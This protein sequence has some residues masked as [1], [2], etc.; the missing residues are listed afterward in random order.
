MKNKVIDMFMRKPAFI[1]AHFVNGMTIVNMS[2]IR[3]YS[4]NH[5]Y[6]VKK[7]F[8]KLGIIERI[9]ETADYKLT[10]KGLDIHNH[11]KAII[12]KV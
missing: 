10:S 12:Q 11:L 1:I 8:E 2:K 3:D 6:K 5:T 9:E 4:Y 7:Q